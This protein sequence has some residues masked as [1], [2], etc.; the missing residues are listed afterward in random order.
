MTFKSLWTREVNNSWL[1]AHEIATK[2]CRSIRTTRDDRRIDERP[3]TFPK[4]D[5]SVEVGMGGKAALPTDKLLLGYPVS[6]VAMPAHRTS[7][8]TVRG[9]YRNNGHSSQ[10]RLVGDEGTELP[11]G[12]TVQ[13]CSLLS[14]SLDPS[15]NVGQFLQHNRPLCA[16]GFR[17]DLLTD[18]VVYVGSEAPLSTRKRLEFSLSRLCFF[19]LK[20][21]SEVAMPVSDAFQRLATMRLT[22]RVGSD[23]CHTQ[24]QTK[25]VGHFLRGLLGRIANG[26]EI[27]HSFM[28]DQIRFALP[29]FKKRQLPFSADKAY[30]D[31]TRKS[32]DRDCLVFY[33]P[34][35]DTVIVRD[36]PGETKRALRLFIEPVSVSYLSNTTNHYLCSQAKAL[37]SFRVA[38]LLH[39]KTLKVLRRPGFVGKP[40]AT[41][42]GAHKRLLQR[43]GLL[44]RGLQPYLGNQ[45]QKV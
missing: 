42:V 35:Q 11:E 16:F 40:V 32:P 19:L 10:S 36:G 38:I 27:E 12:P 28:Q 1:N 3:A 9:G 41:L 5:G 44:L 30:L 6:L 37:P 7:A 22:V 23:I 20:L 25:K 34:A 29:C 31:A 45:F 26:G 39:S 8:R 17:N 14:P 21:G 13:N 15:A 33:V 24:I 4:D 18:D 2:L 43:M